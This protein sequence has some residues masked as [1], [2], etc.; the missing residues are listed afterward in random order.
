[1][2]RVFLYS[3]WSMSNCEAR[4]RG[5]YFPVEWIKCLCKMESHLVIY[6]SSCHDLLWMKQS[7]SLALMLGTVLAH[8]MITVLLLLSNEQVT[9]P[10]TLWVTQSLWQGHRQNFL[11]KWRS[12]PRRQRWPWWCTEYSW[13]RDIC[14]Q[15]HSTAMAWEGG[16]NEGWVSNRGNVNTPTPGTNSWL[17]EPYS[18]WCF[19]SAHP[20][21]QWT[22]QW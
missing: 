19:L 11:L 20:E 21:I 3:K 22:W 12:K 15:P 10:N 5:L 14:Q 6:W 18:Q 1:M 7:P 4:L 16:D 9:T 13:M 17:L 2:L 8:P